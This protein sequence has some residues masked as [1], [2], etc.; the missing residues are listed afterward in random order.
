[1]NRILVSED[2]VNNSQVGAAYAEIESAFGKVPNIFR[3][4]ASH[5][6]LLKSNW[7][8]LKAVMME[9]KLRRVVKETIAVLISEENGCSYCVAAHS[10]ALRMLGMNDQQLSELQRDL[11]V[12]DF[13]R[14]EQLLIRLGK[15]ANQSPHDVDDALFRQLRVEGT[16]DEEILEALGV[17]EV[18]IALNHFAD[19]LRIEVDF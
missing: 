6:A 15:Q 2:N 5:P 13:S 10:A 11:S 12:Y 19:V 1:M 14:K 3:A 7:E 16:E 18:F 4:Y 17:M 9:G 8:K